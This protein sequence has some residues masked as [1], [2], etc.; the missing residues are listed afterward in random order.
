MNRSVLRALSLGA[1]LVPSVAL[2]HTGHGDTGGFTHGFMHP[3]GG[4][5]HVLAMVTV[6]ILAAQLGGRAIW[7]VPASFVGVMLLGVMLGLSGMTLPLVE[8]AIASSVVALGAVVALGLRMPVAAA[9]AMVGAF[10]V[11]HGYAHGAEMPAE[12]AAAAY[13]AGFVSATALL[14]LA[15]LAL[16]TIVVRGGDA[17]LLRAAGAA[18]AVV[19][20]ILVTGVA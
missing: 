1:V 8:I 6:G 2:A 19:G 18:V 5:D 20:A 11:F 15:G 13:A 17:R 16:G 14:H 3:V 12:T 4:L 7:L 9:M 10:A